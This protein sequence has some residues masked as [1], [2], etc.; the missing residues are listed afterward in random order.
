[1]RIALLISSFF[2]FSI[3]LA[4]TVAPVIVIHGGAGTLERGMLSPEEESAITEKLN[5]ALEVGYAIMMKGGSATEA[6]EAS[7]VILEDAPQ[8][9]AGKGAVMTKE[10]KH[11]LDASIMD[12]SNLEAGAVSG[13]TTIKNPIKAAKL[14]LNKSPHVLLYGTGAEDFAK[15]EKIE[16]VKNSYFTTKSV[17]ENWDAMN[18]GEGRQNNEFA[19]FSK[20]GTVG[21]VALDM[22]GNLAAGTSTGGLMNKAFNRIGDSP[23]I[24]AGTYAN[25]ETCAISCTGQGEYF[26]R[27]GVAKEISDQMEFGRKNLSDA[28]S[29]TI[30]KNLTSMNA[31]GG[32]IALDKKG[33]I[34]MPFNTPGMF[35]AY[36]KNRETVVKMYGQD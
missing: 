4:Q 30:D 34:A 8:F 1:M 18:K 2:L 16:T 9:N 14:V 25:N 29:Y 6:V 13:V 26:I 35:R 33:N 21:C 3:C 28:A 31:L 12:G 20:F 24:G 11:E 36:K 15:G 17:K 7:I 22:E 5:Q 32:L 10:G 23:I 27:I 19:K